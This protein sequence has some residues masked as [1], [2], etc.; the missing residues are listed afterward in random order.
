[1][2]DSFDNFINATNG[3]TIGEGECWDYINL[4]WSHLGSKYWTYPPDD[5]TATN[6]GVKWG[7]LNADAFSAN[8]IA[9]LTFISN[10]GDV[11]RGDIVVTTGGNFGHAGFINS[12]YVAGITTYQIYSQ[13]YEGRHSVGMDVYSI[14]EF[15][16]AFRYEAWN[17]PVEKMRHRFPFVLYARKLRNR[18]QGLML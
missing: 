1:M 12:D 18:R 5:P 2:Y 9:G 7:V 4:I 11:K 17:I 13:N 14:A 16:G 3:Q 6:H 10:I 8:Q 15:G